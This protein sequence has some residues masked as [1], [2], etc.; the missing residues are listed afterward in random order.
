MHATDGVELSW[1][2]VE[3]YFDRA[4][5]LDEAV[6]LNLARRARRASTGRRQSRSCSA[7][8]TRCA[9]RSRFSARL[10]V[11]RRR[12]FRAGAARHRRETRRAA[13]GFGRRG[14]E[15]PPRLERRERRRTVPADPRD[16]RRRH[17][18]RVARRA[19][20][21]PTQARSGTQA[22]ADRTAHAGR[23][24]PAR[25]RH[26]RGA[27]ASQHRAPVRRGLQR[28]RPALSR[29]G[30]RRRHAAARQLRRARCSAFARDCACSC[31]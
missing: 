19:Q 26:P 23:A 11:R 10:G 8:T 29:D 7:R 1:T 28:I 9:E 15:I 18:Q 21:R 14:G 4:L 17:E 27:H 20:R 16:R 30:I 13:D 22:A 24:L 2:D 31:R 5:Q 25:A 12:E 3:P 6:V